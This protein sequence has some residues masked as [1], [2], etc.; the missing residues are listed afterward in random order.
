MTRPDLRKTVLSALFLAMGAVLPLFFSQLKEIGDSL[1]PMHIPVLLCGLVCG[2]KY[3]CFVGA[4]LPFFRALFFGMPPLYPNAVW[5]ALEMATYGLVIGLLYAKRPRRTAWL[6]VSLI[7]AMLVGRA[8]WGVSKAVLLGLKG[9]V[10]TLSAFWFGGFADAL[11]G[12][13]LQLILIPAIMLLI[14]KLRV[15]P[16]ES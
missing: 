4:I 12:I 7:V 8:V 9:S 5:M 16:T 15:T 11:P 6:Y 1:L 3:G 2:A 10:F 14:N 13:A